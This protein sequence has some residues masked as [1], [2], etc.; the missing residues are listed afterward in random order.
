MTNNPTLDQQR[1]L[2]RKHMEVNGITQ[3]ELATMIGRSPKHVSHVLTGRSGTHELDYWAWV[4]G[5]KFTVKLVKR[6]DDE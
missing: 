3:N 5:L 1:E 4:L 2:L 6:G